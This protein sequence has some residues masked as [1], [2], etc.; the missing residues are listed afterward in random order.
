MNFISIRLLLRPKSIHEANCRRGSE[1]HDVRIEYEQS[2]EPYHREGYTAD[3]SGTCYKVTP[4]FA[5]SAFQQLAQVVGLPEAALD[6][7]FYGDSGTMPE[8]YR[9]AL[10]SGR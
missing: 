6:V 3:R 9:H 5:G 8:K 10:Q 7:H 4:A 2:R 1:V